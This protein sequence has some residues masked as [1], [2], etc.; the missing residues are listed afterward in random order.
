MGLILSS[1]AMAAKPRVVVVSKSDADAKASIN[2]HNVNSHNNSN[3]NNNEA[4]GG[5]ATATGGTASADSSATGGNATGGN[6]SNGGVSV[7]E[8]AKTI[9]VSTAYSTSLT[10]GLDTCLGSGSGG[11]QLVGVG[12]TG[13]K[14]YKDTHCLM[15]KDTQLLIQMDLK[16]AAC[17]RARSGEDGKAN[18]DAM[19]AAG[20]DC[21]DYGKPVVPVVVVME[22]TDAVTHEE[23]NLLIQKKLIK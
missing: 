12:V 17:F 21:N 11:L 1:V 2:T 16:Q 20:V 18:D 5:N 9:P 10:S 3:V 7:V 8:Q 19:K 6:A 23:L 14:T 22:P 15:I 4:T 13:G